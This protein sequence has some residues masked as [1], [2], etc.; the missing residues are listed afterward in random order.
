MKVRHGVLKVTGS[1][2][3]S[4]MG[5]PRLSGYGQSSC[6]LVRADPGTG[7]GGSERTRTRAGGRVATALATKQP[8]PASAGAVYGK[9]GSDSNGVKSCGIAS[10]SSFLQRGVKPIGPELRCF[11]GPTLMTAYA[12]ARS[13]VILSHRHDRSAR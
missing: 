12:R 9:D 6:R 3:A 7:A 1:M 8:M 4:V 5:G 2:P 10:C 13:S 11:S